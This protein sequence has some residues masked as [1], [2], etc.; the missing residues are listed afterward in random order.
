MAGT[1]KKGAH[2]AVTTRHVLTFT[3][4]AGVKKTL[5]TARDASADPSQDQ[6]AM[7]GDGSAAPYAVIQGDGSVE[8][9]FSI[10]AHEYKSAI[11]QT[12]KT[13]GL[14][15]QELIFD[16]VMSSKVDGL[17]KFVQEVMGCQIGGAPHAP[18]AA[19]SMVE[20][21]GIALNVK[22]DGVAHFKEAQ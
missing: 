2:S 4:P 14:T 16:W 6:E 3:R 12:A 15:I 21:S 1:L 9:G 19:G 10:A 20:M 8:W 5:L 17:D 11:V 13:A 18:D 22:T 7:H